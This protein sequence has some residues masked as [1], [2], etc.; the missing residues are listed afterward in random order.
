VEVEEEAE[1]VFFISCDANP[2]EGFSTLELVDDEVVE[3]E[4]PPEGL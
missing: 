4:T 3:V 2:Y 1:L